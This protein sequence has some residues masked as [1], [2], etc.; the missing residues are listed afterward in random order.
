[1]SFVP[2][3]VEHSSARLLEFETLRELLGGYASS[4]LGKGRIAE[5]RASVDRSWIENQ[6]ALTTEIR[7]F[8]ECRPGSEVRAGRSHHSRRGRRRYAI[9]T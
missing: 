5:L 3:P 1:M 6:H 8:R 7:E 9:T 2:H 4:P